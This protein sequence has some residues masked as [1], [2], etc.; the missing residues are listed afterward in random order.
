MNRVLIDNSVLALGL[1]FA[2]LFSQYLFKTKRPSVGKLSVF[3]LT[4]GSSIVHMNVWAHLFAVSIVNYQIAQQGGFHYDL[5]FYA[6]IQFGVV[7]MLLSGYSLDQV[8][9]LVRGDMIARKRLLY[10]IGLTILFSVPLIPFN[11]IA[12]LPTLGSLVTLITLTVTRKQF[13]AS[14]KEKNIAQP[15]IVLS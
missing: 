10:S 6:L 2:L 14:A 7:L 15:E 12:S 1:L 11:P 5:R 13:D 8:K 9:H 3:F 4:L